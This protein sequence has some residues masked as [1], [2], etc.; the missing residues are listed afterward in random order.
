MD[1]EYKG[2]N[3]IVITANKATIA[4]DPNLSGLGLRDQG[5]KA[6]VH[7]LTQ[8]AFAAPHSEATLVFD[9]PGEYEVQ[10]IS[11]MGIAARAYGDAKTEPRRA[12]IYRID[13]AGSSVAII[14]HIHPD[15]T[16]EDLEA[17]GIVDAIILPVGGNGYTLDATGAVKIIRAFDPKPKVVIPTYYADTSYTTTQAELELFI[18]ELS[19]P[20]EETTKVKLKAG[21]LSD[22]QTLY[23]VKRTA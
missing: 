1:I 5:Q 8:T 9:G 13:A 23:E 17:I 11:I 16:D 2:G 6:T 19:A 12:T 20:K 7:L 3:C 18:K 10:D 4:V 14:G 21:I 15:L 22:T